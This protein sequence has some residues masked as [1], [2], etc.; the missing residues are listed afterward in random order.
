MDTSSRGLGYIL[1]KVH[2]ETTD[3]DNSDGSSRVVRFGS[4]GISKWQRH[5]G[6]TKLELLGM[7]TAI[8]DCASYLR[9]RKFVVECDH[10]SLRP[11]FQKKLQGAI[12]ERWLSILTWNTSL[13]LKWLC[14]ML[15]HVANLMEV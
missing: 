11:L 1:Y 6:P 5:Y 13:L 2:P 7:T 8:I 14:R 9:G 4:K 10:L 3:S 12:Y 15:Y